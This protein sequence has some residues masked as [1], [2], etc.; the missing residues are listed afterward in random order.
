MSPKEPSP[1]KTSK[2]CRSLH[3]PKRMVSVK[4]DQGLFILQ[5]YYNLYDF[6]VSKSC[7]NFTQCCKK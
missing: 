1:K 7:K 5:K 3:W 4:S 6:M 2:A